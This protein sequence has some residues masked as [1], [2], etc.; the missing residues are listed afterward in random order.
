M[1]RRLSL[2]VCVVLL[3]LVTLCAFVACDD[4]QEE[5]AETPQTS[6]TF[7]IQYTD[8]SGTHT[9]N[10]GHGMPYSLESIPQ[11]I[12][13]DF[14]GLYDSEVGGTQYV[15]AA[16]ASISPY[17]DLKNI[18]LFPQYKAKQ[19]TIIL[20]FDGT[21]VI[22]SREKTVEYDSAIGELPMGLIKQNYNFKGWYTEKNCK[23]TQIADEYGVF[24]QRKIVNATNYDLSDGS[25]F[26][27]LYAGFEGVPQ[28]LTLYVNTDTYEYIEMDVPYG[29]HIKDVVPD[30]RDSRGY[31]V[32]SWTASPEADAT[33]PLFN[34]EI[35]TDLTLY[36]VEFAPVIELDSNGGEKV[37]SVIARVGT[38]IVLPE[39]K[40]EKY[41]FGGW[42]TAN[43]I[44]YA[45]T[46]MPQNS[47]Q[48]T[49]KWLLTI[50]LDERGG[51]DV[52]DVI[53]EPGKTIDLP[54]PSKNGYIFAGWYS[55][56]G[57]L[58][59]A[60]TMPSTNMTL[61]AKYRKILTETIVIFDDS[62]RVTADHTLSPNYDLG[63]YEVDLS[64][65]YQ[66]RE[67]NIDVCAKYSARYYKGYG[68]ISSSKPSYTNMTWY[69]TNIISNSNEIWEYSDK[70]TSS[71]VWI[72]CEHTT[73][74]SLNSDKLYF[75]LWN[76]DNTGD[77]KY[78]GG[79]WINFW[80]EIE[81]PDMTTLY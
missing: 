36:A 23:G 7:T 16:G 47:I 74:I 61:V 20:D 62:A 49:A 9:I 25:N 69:S 19:Y 14:I 12:G 80:L 10:V 72:R 21:E 64:S 33:A 37:S 73:T 41:V 13:Y 32:Y 79:N 1:K 30:Y 15:N 71:L 50:K 51:S 40:R 2:L 75:A 22:G 56:Q 43:N 29:T 34:D 57:A 45:E 39:P 65:I 38:T 55:E 8:D 48:L 6:L 11:R 17:Y 31:G 66:G 35:T 70:H 53:D 28:H 81:Y 46:V 44:K 60:K 18:V 26:I 5:N 77:N 58:F 67:M 78:S 54:E 63:F 52:N 59:T 76:T 68:S 3:A 4:K 27:Y 24:P 42:Y